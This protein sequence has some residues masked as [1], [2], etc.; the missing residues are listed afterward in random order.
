MVRFESPIT[1]FINSLGFNS[2]DNQM[3]FAGHVVCGAWEAGEL[4][5][6]GE[7]VRMQKQWTK[8]FF[9]VPNNAFIYYTFQKQKVDKPDKYSEFSNAQ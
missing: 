3:I 6:M 8:L 1:K 5:E 7:R 9:K 2:T 4:E